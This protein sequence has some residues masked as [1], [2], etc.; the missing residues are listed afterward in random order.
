M[1]N[2][3]DPEQHKWI[4]GRFAAVVFWGFGQHILGYTSFKFAMTI[5]GEMTRSITISA[6]FIIDA[7]HVL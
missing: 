7:H 2:E 6:Q 5:F 4:Q 1:L 3:N